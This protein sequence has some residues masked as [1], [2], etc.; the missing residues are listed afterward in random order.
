MMHTKMALSELEYAKS[1]Q[2]IDDRIDEIDKERYALQA[3]AR[4]LEFHRRVNA[5]DTYAVL[6]YLIRL[7]RGCGIDVR[8]DC[9][10]MMIEFPIK[11]IIKLLF[12]SNSELYQPLCSDKKEILGGIVDGLRI[13]EE[14]E[15]KHGKTVL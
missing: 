9:D 3:Q 7:L 12:S 11:S 10:G 4:N 8:L 15:R 1:R 6:A 2:S 13:A 14:A 5:D